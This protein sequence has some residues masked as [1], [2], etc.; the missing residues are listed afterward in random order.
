MNYKEY[1]LKSVLS[2]LYNYRLHKIQKQINANA[3]P[4]LDN[5]KDIILTEEEKRQIYSVWGRM[6]IDFSLDYFKIFKHYGFFSPFFVTN[7]ILYPWILNVLNPLDFRS[8]FNH[9]GLYPVFYEGMRRPETAVYCINGQCYGPDN[10]AIGSR[11]L[12]SFTFTGDWIVKPTL[13][14]GG[15]GFRVID[16]DKDRLPLLIKEYK[17]D[18]IV[19]EKLKQSPKTA[20]FNDSSLNTFRVTSLFLNDKVSVPS[21]IFK[22]GKKGAL[23]DNVAAGSGTVV[24][25]TTDGQFLDSAF[26]YLF[27]KVHTY[28]DGK[29]L[30]DVR[31]DEVKDIVDFVRENHQRYL[32]SMGV[33]GW[34]MALDVDNKPVMIEVNTLYP[35]ILLVQLAN[36]TPIMGERT[37]EVIDVVCKCRPQ[38][39]IP[40]NRWFF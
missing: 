2:R 25:L 20:V 18:F 12:E 1:L 34:D 14:H 10:K 38:L 21:I 37:E 15:N 40:Y 26:N 11:C 39:E 28:A 17:G 4:P 24:G 33:V 9:K 8:A 29:P 27:D 6:K 5:F 16:N 23:V 3:H 36:K 31:I 35:G 22:Y 32:P 30:K 19:Q 7:D 13:D